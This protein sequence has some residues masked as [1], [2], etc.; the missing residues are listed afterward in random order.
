MKNNKN[1]KKIQ[2]YVNRLL[3][4]LEKHYYHQYNHALDV[5][6]RSI[7][8]W[9]KEWLNKEEIEM[10][11]IA[12]MF[13]DTGFIIQYNDN[14]IFWAQIADNYLKTIIYPKEKV[15]IIRNLIMATSPKYKDTKNILE[16]IIKDADMDNLWRDDFFDKTNEIKKELE[17][18]KK[19]KIK[20][21]DWHHASLDLLYEH[22]FLT[23]TEKNER[24][25]KLDDNKKKLKKIIN[26]EKLKIY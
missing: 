14:E 9:K 19:I 18:I 17:A 24:N 25:N 4:P 16:D 22:K 21:P 2:K 8:L 13:H 3:I 12:S 23:N 11:A 7:Y 15:K 6:D 5:M 10:L 1:I 20:E 26:D